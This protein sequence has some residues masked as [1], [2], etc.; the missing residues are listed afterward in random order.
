VAGTCIGGALGIFSV[1]FLCPLFDSIT[2]FL[3]SCSGKIAANLEQLA[4][5]VRGTTEPFIDPAPLAI[6]DATPDCRTDSLLRY[7]NS[8]ASCG[9]YSYRR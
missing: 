6:G 9:I 7:G 8:A 1:A 2:V 4:D 5:H 3:R